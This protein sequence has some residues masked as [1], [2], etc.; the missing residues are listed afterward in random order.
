LQ[1]LNLLRQGLQHLLNLLKLL[2]HDLN[3]LLQTMDVVLKELIE[4][5]E[6]PKLLRKNLHQ[7]LQRLREGLRLLTIAE[8]QL[9]Q[10]LRRLQ[11]RIADRRSAISIW[12]DASARLP[13][14][15]ELRSDACHGN[16]L[17]SPC[18]RAL[19]ELTRSSRRRGPLPSRTPFGTVRLN[20]ARTLRGMRCLLFRTLSRSGPGGPLAV[21]LPRTIH[22]DV[23]VAAT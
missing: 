1:L 6:L 18:R 5:I 23:L 22:R 19:P 8:R 20:A 14:L 9:L 3:Q 16:L 13:E 12:R 15:A 7:L 4:L 2:R 10:L 21:P 11:E 17:D